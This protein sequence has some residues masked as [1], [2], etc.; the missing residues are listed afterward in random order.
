MPRR[1]NGT[2]KIKSA[3]NKT[4]RRS[5]KQNGNSKV[6]IKQQVDKE[7]ESENVTENTTEANRKSSK[8]KATNVNNEMKIGNQKRN[9]STAANRVEV[10]HF[11][12]DDQIV[13][14]MVEGQESEFVSELEDSDGDDSEVILNLSQQSVNNNATLLKE[15]GEGSLVQD[16]E[17]ENPL[18]SS[19][20]TAQ[21]KDLIIGQSVNQALAQVQNIIDKSGFIETASRLNEQLKR[22]NE[23]VA[24]QVSGSKHDGRGEQGKVDGSFANLSGRRKSKIPVPIKRKPSALEVTIY[25]N[26]VKDSTKR[27]SSSS[28]EADTSDDI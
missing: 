3:D 10:V 17:I 18:T 8:R 23:L 28:E 7:V 16:M 5:S 15:V 13:E 19:G 21:E 6:V 27:V 24:A 26:A 25:E 20:K 9:R 2:S 1:R 12:E 22:N 4:G 11:I 14:M